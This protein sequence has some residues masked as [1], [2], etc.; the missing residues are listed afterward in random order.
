METDSP[1]LIV[2]IDELLEMAEEWLYLQCGGNLIQLESIWG[3]AKNAQKPQLVTILAV[4][5]ASQSAEQQC[6]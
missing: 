6:R 1:R 5:L 4:N 2:L 3:T